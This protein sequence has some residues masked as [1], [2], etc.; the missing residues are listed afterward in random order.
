MKH[1]I[2]AFMLA[3]CVGSVAADDYLRPFDSSDRTYTERNWKSESNRLRFDGRSSDNTNLNVYTKPE[4]GYERN[5]FSNPQVYPNLLR[6]EW[7]G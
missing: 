3:A 5:E 1:I 6:K 4:A 7:G 2:L